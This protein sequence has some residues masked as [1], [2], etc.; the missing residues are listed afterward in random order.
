MK[1]RNKVE[2]F[3]EIRRE[4]EFGVGTISGVARKF[5]VHR[6][7]V[8]EA[9]KSALPAPRKTPQRSSP[10][11]DLVRDFIF[12]TEHQTYPRQV[13]LLAAVGCIMHLEYEP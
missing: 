1:R 6:R 2:L 8:R 9:I 7:M 3:E 10:K 4:Y 13:R 11:L 12:V 5:N